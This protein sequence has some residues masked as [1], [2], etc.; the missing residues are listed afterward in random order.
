MNNLNY[1]NIKKISNI[2]IN[3]TPPF[4]RDKLEYQY[5]TKKNLCNG[6]YNSNEYIIFYSINLLI[7]FIGIFSFV[8]YYYKSKEEFIKSPYYIGLFI[9]AEI[10]HRNIFFNDYHMVIYTDQ[11]TFSIL[12][13]LFCVYPKVILAIVYWKKY[14]IKDKIEGS[15]LRCLRYH[16]LDAFP[17]SIILIRDADTLFITEISSLAHVY[18]SGVKGINK[19]G[20]EII[21]Y[22]DFLIDK[23]GIWEE[24][25]IKL[26]KI[27]ENPILLGVSLDYLAHWH[28]ELPL[29]YPI[30]KSNR[31]EKQRFNNYEK[32]YE[33]KLYLISPFG[34][35]AGFVNFM[36]YRPNDIWLYMYDYIYSHYKLCGNKISN[37]YIWINTIG[38]DERLLIFIVIVKYWSLCFFLSIDYDIS[39][40]R[41]YYTNNEIK[42]MNNSKKINNIRMNCNKIE[43]KSIL[44]NLG[45][46]EYKKSRKNNFIKNHVKILT[47]LLTPTY[48]N[49]SFNA[50]I[51]NSVYNSKENNRFF[52]CSKIKNWTKGKTINEIFKEIFKKFSKEYL[53][54]FYSFMNKDNREINKIIVKL[55]RQPQNTPYAKLKTTNF[56]N[57]PSRINKSR[58]PQ[59]KFK[60]YTKI[61]KK[62]KKNNLYIKPNNQIKTIINPKNTLFP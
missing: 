38:K 48:L 54:W 29:I 14:S 35:F 8:L 32:E 9:Y 46:I 45:Y 31:Y 33:N 7:D 15:I 44:L 40:I 6:L 57:F 28:S 55:F 41:K 39:Y 59:I 24:K 27:K 62:N 47:T 12:S 52:S 34:I 49:K 10:I 22:I 50:K 51:N 17:N 16:A 1:M 61:N 11:E 37:H 58:L 25:F 4:R 3:I 36:K 5:E 60:D 13:E 53:V 56:Y 30:K 26:W 42:N 43:N 19:D 23:I 20:T 18:S 21:D 2:N